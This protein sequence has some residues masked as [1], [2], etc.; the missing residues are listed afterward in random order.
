MKEDDKSFLLQIYPLY[1]F[2]SFV[3]V[4]LWKRRQN[5]DQNDKQLSKKEVSVERYDNFK[6]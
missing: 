1:H 6:F 2:Y 4:K 5:K 3:Q